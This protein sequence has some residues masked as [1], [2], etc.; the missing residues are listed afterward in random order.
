MPS[1]VMR[2]LWAL[3]VCLAMPLA[4]RAEVSTLDKKT[5]AAL[6]HYIMGTMYDDLGD[7]DRAIEEYKEAS[8][9]DS[10]NSSIH[11][12]LASSY[13]KKNQVD[14]A[15]E[16]LKAVTTFD[17]EAVEPHTILALIYSL[18]NKPE[19]AAAELEAALKNASKKEPQNADIYKNLG[20]VYLQQKRFKEAQE[21]FLLATKLAPLDAQGHFYLASTYNEL[22]NNPEAEKELKRAIDLNA[23]YHEA[24]NFL[25]YLFVE[26]NRNLPQAEV[27][28][29]KAL[30]MEPDNGAYI[31]S[32]GWLY[33]KKGKI[34]EALT[35]L[36]KASGLVDD[37]VIFDHL[38]E[39]YFKVSD[40]Q[41]AKVSWQKA[42]KLDPKHDRVAEKLN[43]LEK[44][45]NKINPKS[46]N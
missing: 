23:D 16:E 18:Q 35:E 42:L 6:S 40:K 30:K 39:A 28:I 20:L 29:R 32:L 10:R 2:T 11:L 43:R 41:K 12:S 4:A 8:Q 25:G 33:F 22:K 34:K 1:R 3:L 36:E 31:D 37:P 15:V 9:A 46:T 21:T 44:Q 24:L 45:C 27:M 13:I 7:I 26:E 38:G 5:S 14:K 19:P 17:P